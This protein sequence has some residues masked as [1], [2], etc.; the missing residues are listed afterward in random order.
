MSQALKQ[1][2]ILQ[3][4]PSDLQRLEQV[5]QE[6]G[7]FDIVMDGLNVC[8]GANVR[9]FWNGKKIQK[10]KRNYTETG[11]SKSVYFMAIVDHHIYFEY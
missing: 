8:Y 2:D 5:V 6:N 9:N 11:S 3:I 7:P 10:G 4:R 1:A